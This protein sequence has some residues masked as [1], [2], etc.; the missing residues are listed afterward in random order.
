MPSVDGFP[1]NLR[2]G[3][4]SVILKD[5]RFVGN[6]KGKKMKQ[7]QYCRRWFK[8]KRGL[9]VHIAMIHADVKLWNKYKN[10]K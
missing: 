10:R 2:S 3:S 7:C 5:E 8:T 1:N 4:L 9:Q 6:V